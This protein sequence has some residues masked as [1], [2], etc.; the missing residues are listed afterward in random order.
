[1]PVRPFDY[2]VKAG[3]S[4]GSKTASGRGEIMAQYLVSIHHP[5]N[6]DPSTVTEETMREARKAVLLAPAP[7]RRTRRRTDEIHLFGIHRARE[8]RR[9]DRGRAT[10]SVRRML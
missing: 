6:F 3:Q 10:R 9:D 8:I 4:P 2:V 5:D 7:G 1:M